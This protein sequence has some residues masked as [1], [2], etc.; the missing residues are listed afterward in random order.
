M[1]KKQEET[2]TKNN[3]TNLK[4]LRGSTKNEPE[5]FSQTPSKSAPH[6]TLTT[7]NSTAA[8]IQRKKGPT[9]RVTVKYDVGFSNGIF[10]RGKGANLS[11][12]KGIP[13]KNVKNDEWVWETDAPFSTCEFKVL[14]NDSCYE[15]GDNH[16]LTCGATVQYTPKFP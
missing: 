16:P 12:E 11:W 9:T 8:S 14:I 13:L 7:P 4:N 6:T 5:L 2:L 1:I 3:P 10:L 15:L